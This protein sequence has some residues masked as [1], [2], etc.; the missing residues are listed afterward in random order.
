MNL[1]PSGCG[2]G[3]AG[4]TETPTCRTRK[5][6]SGVKA[7]I[8]EEPGKLAVVDRPRPEPKQDEVLVPLHKGFD[9]LAFFCP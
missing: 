1:P 4:H 3:R 7:V 2:R 8:C 5:R 6:R 9:R